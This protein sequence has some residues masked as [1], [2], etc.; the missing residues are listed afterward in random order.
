MK[1][2]RPRE[3]CGGWLTLGQICNNSAAVANWNNSTTPTNTSATT[4]L[5]FHPDSYATQNQVCFSLFGGYIGAASTVSWQ[6]IKS[7]AVHTI[8]NQSLAPTYLKIYK[9]KTRR[10]VVPQWDNVAGSP[11]IAA[12]NFQQDPNSLLQD[13]GFNGTAGGTVT[14]SSFHKDF[15]PYLAHGFCAQYK[16]VSTTSRTLPPGARLTIKQNGKSGRKSMIQYLTSGDTNSVGSQV[17]L[18]PQTT[19]YA[20]Q[21]TGDLLS[22][23]TVDTVA[24]ATQ[25]SHASTALT[26]STRVYV[27]ASA[28][29]LNGTAYTGFI[30]G[31]ASVA[32]QVNA[33]A[34]VADQAINAL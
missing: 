34:V 13:V 20:I 3:Y 30:D 16:I 26:V 12:T 33:P 1:E 11:V 24:H 4:I 15:S 31:V 8:V 32:A 14:F 19:L 29:N 6:I 18:P 21:V 23:S 7:F 5:P 27:E 17:V 10:P 22:S 28:F 9:L 2:G 25:V